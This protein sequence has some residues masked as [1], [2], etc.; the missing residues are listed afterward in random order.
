MIAHPLRPVEERDLV[1]HADLGEC[2]LVWAGQRGEGKPRSHDAGQP[3]RIEQPH[4]VVLPASHEFF[5]DVLSAPLLPQRHHVEH[6][7][8][9]SV[10]NP[11]SLEQPRQRRPDRQDWLTI[12]QLY[13]HRLHPADRLGL[14]PADRLLPAGG[15]LRRPLLVP[16]QPRH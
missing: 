13:L 8:C 12:W 6:E 5:R 7:R 16:V 2:N 11:P 3:N 15:E 10:R 4:E 9:Q 14:P 1:S